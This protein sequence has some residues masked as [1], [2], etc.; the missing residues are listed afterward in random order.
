MRVE[1][2][3]RISTDEDRQPF[4]L[5]A[6]DQRLRA[7]VVSQGWELVGEPFADQAFGASLDGPQLARL[8]EVA[9]AAGE[10]DVVLVYR[11][12]RIARTLRGLVKLLDELDRAGVVFRSATEPFDTASP[13]GRMM[14]QMLG[15]FAEFERATIIDRITAGMERKAARGE[16]Q[17][18]RRPHGYQVDHGNGHLVVDEFEAPQVAA[19]FD[20]YTRRRLSAAAV[21]RELTA[22]GW[23]TQ[24]DSAWTSSAVL[25]VLRNRVYLGEIYYRSTWHTAPAGPHHPPLVDPELFEQAQQILHARRNERAQ[26]ATGASGYLLSGLVVCDRCGKTYLGSTA[27]GRSARYRYYTCTTRSRFGIAGCDAPRLPADRVEDTVIGLVAAS[28]VV[29]AHSDLLEEAVTRLAERSDGRRESLQTEL[30][31]IKSELRATRRQID[32]YL[33]AFENDTMPV[34]VCAERLTALNAKETELT[35]REA[36]LRQQLALAA[37]RHDRAVDLEHARAELRE[38]LTTAAAQTARALYRSLVTRVEAYD[39]RPTG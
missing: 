14:V 30:A 26:R 2:Y 1:L 22:K 27:Q 19:I 4:S 11:V 16:W 21:A 29:G 8:L 6:Q 7:Y 35:A 15:V 36:V 34:E 9:R 20:L 23:R 33:T 25:T 31:A 3:T 28:L 37:D 24:Q 10:I 39:Q 38:I 17:N 13:A 18:G 32:R 5:V 12:D